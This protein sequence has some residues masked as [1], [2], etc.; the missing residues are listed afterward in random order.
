MRGPPDAKPIQLLGRWR[1]ALPIRDFEPPPDAQ[2][3][4]GQNVRSPQI[5]NQQHLDRPA[6]DAL[7]AGQPFNKFG[8]GQPVA[9][10]ER[11][12]HPVDGFLRKVA[13]VVR[14]GARQPSGSE[15]VNIQ[16]NDLGWR[17]ERF[18]VEQGPEPFQDCPR[19]RTAELLVD[20][21]MSEGLERRKSAGFQVGRAQTGNELRHDGVGVAQMLGGCGHGRILPQTVTNGKHLWCMSCQTSIK[22]TDASSCRS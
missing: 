8:I 14:L 19:G 22:N 18:P 13:D 21:G 4:D 11:W 17:W 9:F 20:D 15:P 2:V 10:S 12:H 6:A 16:L 3:V 5:E 1:S 7:D